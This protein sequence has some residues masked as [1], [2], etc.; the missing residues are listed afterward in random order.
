[1]IDEYPLHRWVLVDPEISSRHGLPVH[2]GIAH[3]THRMRVPGGWIY[4]ITL[5]R[6]HWL[7]RDDMHVS[8][9]FVPDQPQNS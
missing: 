1:M 3:L 4:Q 2:H 6:M 8:T 5:L 7:R 9:L